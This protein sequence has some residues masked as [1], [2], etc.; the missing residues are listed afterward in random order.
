MTYTPPEPP[1]PGVPPPWLAPPATQGNPAKANLRSRWWFLAAVAVVAL[2]LGAG[3]GSA[4]SSTD[5]NAKASP[6]VTRTATATATETATLQVTTTP[7]RV[8]ATRT[9]QV[10]VTYTPPPVDETSD[11]QY[12]V[13]REIKPGL[14]HTAGGDAC[15]Y[16]RLRDL[17]GGIDSIITNDNIT[18]PTTINVRSTDMAVSFAGDCVWS[19]IG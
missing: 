13:G 6:A 2:L 5:A 9:V 15:Y 10:R 8:I 12:L 17:N 4:G 3:I 18:G 1:R 19:R 16:E 7:T 11:G 14:W